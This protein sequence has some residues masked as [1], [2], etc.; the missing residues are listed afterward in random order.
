MEDDMSVEVQGREHHAEIKA[1]EDSLLDTIRGLSN[2]IPNGDASHWHFSI[3]A[4]RWAMRSP[5]SETIAS[6]IAGVVALGLATGG[7]LLAWNAS[8][9]LMTPQSGLAAQ[10]GAWAVSA[11]LLIGAGAA[12]F[13]AFGSR[14]LHLRITQLAG[15]EDV[16]KALAVST[17]D[18]GPQASP[19]TAANGAVRSLGEAAAHASEATRLAAIASDAAN[20]ATPDTAA[21][22]AAA[23]ATAHSAAATATN[24]AAIGTESGSADSSPTAQNAATTISPKVWA[25]GVAGAIAFS[26]W[27]IAAATFWKNTFSSETLAALVGSTTAIMAAAAAYF[28]TDPLRSRH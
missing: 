22:A 4:P 28:K 6:S 9:K 21:A 10:I 26:F 3:T 8:D 18:R 16:A 14:R 20:I 7:V 13:A 27:T 23:A 11:M 1:S 5:S 2:R 19:A 12:A 24:A 25:G 17:A 15:G